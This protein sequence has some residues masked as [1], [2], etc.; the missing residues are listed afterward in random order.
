M[1]ELSPD[2]WERGRRCSADDLPYCHRCKP[3]PFPINVVVATGWAA[4]FHASK[5]CKGLND[6]QRM[7]ERHGGSAAPVTTIHRE[8]AISRGY[9]P[10]L[11][12]FPS[13]RGHA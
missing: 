11:L 13:A 9:K 8:V 12:C 3:K 6:G 7:V 2:D 4:A 1:G 10:C 5:D